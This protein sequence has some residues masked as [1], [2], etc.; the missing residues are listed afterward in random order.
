MT[1]SLRLTVLGDPD[2]VV[3]LAGGAE[4][5]GPGVRLLTPTPADRAA[6]VTRYEA[7]VDGWVFEVLVEPSA[8]AALRDRARRQAEATGHHVREIVRARIPGR[9]VRVWVEPG[10]AVGAGERL[11]SVEAMK[12]ENEIRAPRAGTVASVKVTSGQSV[13]LGAEL[14]VLD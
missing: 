12:M 11:L 2:L 5:R 14:V 8:R 9:V 6:G 4:P 13:E 10:Q 7:E 1:G 3:D